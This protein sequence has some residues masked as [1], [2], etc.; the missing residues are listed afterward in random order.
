MEDLE[1]KTP[2]TNPRYLQLAMI[3][4]LLLIPVMSYVSYQGYQNSALLEL[5]LGIYS[6]IMLSVASFFLYRQINS[7]DKLT[8]SE[9]GLTYEF[10][11]I[12]FRIGWEDIETIEFDGSKVIQ[13]RLNAPEKV[14]YNS[15]VTQKPVT[16]TQFNPYTK[17]LLKQ[18]ALFRKT[19]I[20]N[21]QELATLLKDSEKENNY[22]V[23]IPFFESSETAEKVFQQISQLHSQHQPQYSSFITEYQQDSISDSAENSE[24]QRSRHT[25]LE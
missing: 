21:R 16:R 15:L 9:K 20:N 5:L 14:A 22:H 4:C 13:I 2:S 10:L 6:V 1:I 11:N 18:A 25:E 23:A 17:F 8:V 24:R 12:I 7:P 19:W 3:V